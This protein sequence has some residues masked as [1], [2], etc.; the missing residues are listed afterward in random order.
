MFVQR[1]SKGCS[2]EQSEAV[3]AK[4]CPGCGGL[5]LC[6]N[7]LLS[8]ACAFL[9]TRRGCSYPH[10]LH[11]EYNL[12]VLREFGLETLNR[13]SCV[14]FCCRATAYYCHRS[15]MTTIIVVVARAT[16]SVC[17]SKPSAP[18][19]LGLSSE[20]CASPQSVS[21][22]TL[23][24]KHKADKVTSELLSVP[25]EQLRYGTRRT[26]ALPRKPKASMDQANLNPT[27]LQLQETPVT[28]EFAS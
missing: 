21:R 5:H 10:D 22:R 25:G 26:M 6:K 20:P 15:A 8:G 18:P 28:S 9:Q 16:V 24:L 19:V 1:D 27:A 7:I 17:T 11:S 23:A 3:P 14:C 2:P 13:L 4:E 12:Q